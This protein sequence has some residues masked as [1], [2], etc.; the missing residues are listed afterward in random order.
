MIRINLVPA[1]Q[2]YQ[3]SH[4]FFEKEL[5]ISVLEEFKPPKILA[6]KQLKIG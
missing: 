6:E 5:I 4:R 2:R 1:Q 3:K